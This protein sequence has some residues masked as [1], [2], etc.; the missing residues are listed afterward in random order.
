M[1]AK[2]GIWTMTETE[3][4]REMQVAKSEGWDEGYRAGIADK[5]A[6]TSNPHGGQK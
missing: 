1:T 6:Q 5:W 3:F 2:D 4:E